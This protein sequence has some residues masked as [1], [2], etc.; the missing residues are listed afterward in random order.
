[1][2]ALAPSLAVALVGMLVS[3]AGYLAAVTRATT[4]LQTEVPDVL[5]GRVMALWSVCFVGSRPF[6]ALID[7]A[8]AEVAGARV[9]A[10]AM[11]VPSIL[12]AFWVARILAPTTTDVVDPA[13]SGEVS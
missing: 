8:I 9:A 4:R 2:V 6:A 10:A 5:L 11:A 3:G 12:V 13:G 1:V 7:G